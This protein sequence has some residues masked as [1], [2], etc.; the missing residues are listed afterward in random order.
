MR[1]LEN[2]WL[3][4]LRG[5]SRSRR[6]AYF[7]LAGNG[8]PNGLCFGIWARRIQASLNLSRQVTQGFSAKACYCDPTCG[9]QPSMS[10]KTVTLSGRSDI[11]IRLLFCLL[12]VVVT[13]P[14]TARGTFGPFSSNAALQ[15]HDPIWI[16]NNADF[17]SPGHYGNGVT[18]G[19]G[20]TN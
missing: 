14:N 12:L 4:S 6:I 20:T 11:A 1:E 9:K 18:G 19:S 7:L 10:R 15:A 2:R 5:F 8:K 3:E 13:G 17:G 16:H